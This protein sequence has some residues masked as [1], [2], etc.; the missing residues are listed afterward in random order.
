M[1]LKKET[2]KKWILFEQ[3]WCTSNGVGGS[4]PPDHTWFI[5][6]LTKFAHETKTVMSGPI[7]TWGS[8]A[9]TFGRVVPLLR[10]S[11]SD[12]LP[13]FMIVFLHTHL[14]GFL[15]VHLQL[16]GFEKFGV[17]ILNLGVRSSIL[18]QHFSF[19][20]EQH[21]VPRDSYTDQL[22]VMSKRLFLAINAMKTKQFP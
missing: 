8:G 1:N 16:T 10:Y 13:R 4:D 20:C 21:S 12:F 17:C 11:D 7:S 19:H 5:S 22:R 9:P 3:K 15:L 14:H 6:K 2:W 18:D